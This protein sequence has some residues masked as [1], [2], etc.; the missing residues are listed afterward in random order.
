MTAT[1]FGHRD[2]PPEVEIPLRKILDDLIRNRGVRRFYVGDQGRFDKLVLRILSEYQ[3]ANADICVEKVLAYLPEKAQDMPTVYPDGIEKVPFCYAIPFRNRWMIMHAD[4][5]VC[6]VRSS[7]GGAAA[8]A[9]FAK[10]RKKE[11]L[12]L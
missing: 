11:I 10:Q 2:S 12:F 6:Y 8:A 7:Y 3:K 4:I 1:F 5:V 9:E